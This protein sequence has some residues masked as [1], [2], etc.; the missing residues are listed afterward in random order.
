LWIRI[1]WLC[2]SGWVR[3]SYFLTLS[4]KFCFMKTRYRKL[5]EHAVYFLN[6]IFI[7]VIRE[8]QLIQIEKSH[9]IQYILKM[10]QL[11]INRKNLIKPF[12]QAGHYSASRYGEQWRAEP[13]EQS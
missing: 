4:G 1:Q 10:Y 11:I 2:W 13:G 6:Y 5:V 7:L 12:F 8:T 9:S 3:K